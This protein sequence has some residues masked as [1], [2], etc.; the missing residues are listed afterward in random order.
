MSIGGMIG[1]TLLIV[2]T[3]AMILRP[4]MR[5]QLSMGRMALSD[6]QLSQD[7]LVTSYERVLAMI[8][9][10]DEDYHTGK[11]AP[12]TYQ[13]D[14]AYWTEQGIKLLQR[15]E[16]NEDAELPVAA[17]AVEAIDETDA[18]LD[19]AIEKAI[20]EYRKART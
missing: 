14:R 7:E 15:I 4:F 20:S 9:D 3:L 11:L 17:A 16:P 19:D 2:F 6:K 10:L 1:A 18:V 8:R 12:D 13:E 5:K